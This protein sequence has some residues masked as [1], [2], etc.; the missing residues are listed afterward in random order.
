MRRLFS[1]LLLLL[2]IAWSARAVTIDWVPVGNPGNAC[3]AQSQG[4]FGSVAYRYE[5]SKYEITNAQYAAFLNAVAAADPYQLY[6]EGSTT[7]N[8]GIAR[9]GT[10]GGF[11][12]TAI[13]GRE[14]LPVNHVSFY[15]ALRFANWM[16]NGQGSADTETG[17]YTLL[18]GTP[19]PSNAHTVTRNSDASIYL[20]SE[21]EW[22]K[23]AYYDAISG[24]YFDYPAGSSVQTIC[25]PP[26]VAPNR[27]NCSHLF[28][29][30]V[31]VGSY[32]GS[33]SPYGTFDQGGN[34]V[35][36]TETAFGD[37]SVRIL[38]GGSF[39]N[40]ASAL[41]ASSQSGLSAF[42]ENRTIGIRL[43]MIPEPGTG[44]LVVAGLLGFAGW[45]RVRD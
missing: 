4:C 30:A 15:D 10:S 43:V 19:L 41:A 11:T 39:Q 5:I 9:S 38:R 12:Y 23:A 21:D 16:N 26:S 37:G 24:S 33:S 18:G 1:S 22:Y 3:E 14:N 13:A 42:G 29:D 28:F 31:P 27:A 36:W 17:A 34:G 35:E 25:G 44:L 40:G 6:R 2:G 7:S 32:P 8:G 45:R 20:P